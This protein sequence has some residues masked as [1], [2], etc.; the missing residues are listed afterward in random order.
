[1]KEIKLINSSTYESFCTLA[2][3][4]F[5][6]LNAHKWLIG[7]IEET[8][9][10]SLYGLFKENNLIAG[11]RAFLFEMNYDQTT[12]SAGGLG[13]LFVDMLH[14]KEGNA[15]QLVNYFYEINKSTG[16]NLVMLHPF[17]VPFYK[18]MGFGMGT[19]VYQYYLNPQSFQ[20]YSS[21]KHLEHLGHDNRALVLDCYNRVY[22]RTHGMTRRPST[23]RE[24]NRPFNFGQVVGYKRNNKVLG[25]VLYE[26]KEK[27]LYIHELFFETSEA[28]EELS[29][30]LHQQADQFHRIIINSNNDDLL[31]F[32]SAPESGLNTMLDTAPAVDHKH[33][34]NLG[35]GV[36]YRVINCK[37]FFKELYE[38]NHQFGTHSVTIKFEI[39]D[40]LQSEESKE[41]TVNFSKGEIKNFEEH[42]IDTVIKMGI[43]EFSSMMMGAVNF[44]SLLKWGKAEISNP[45]F[46]NRING[47]LQTEERPV[48][49]KAF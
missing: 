8:P 24:L 39:K 14:K 10:E 7:H 1:M 48:C 43:A 49:T 12:I 41:F 26:A 2:N 38:K 34:A 35:V 20:D 28:M 37:G 30:F 13:M 40:D 11:M 33:M 45:E 15:Y 3:R 5:P 16:V 46:V 29:T 32:V 42:Q 47:L 6:G 44:R 17:K 18:K 23:D 27:D 4:A 9:S 31:H 22:R 36:M 19:Y 21:K 25:Y